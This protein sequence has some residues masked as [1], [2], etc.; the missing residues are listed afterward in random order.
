[1]ATVQEA[2]VDGEADKYRQEAIAVVAAAAAAKASGEEKA[3]STAAKNGKESQ[4]GI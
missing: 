1:M 3:T 4:R 2:A